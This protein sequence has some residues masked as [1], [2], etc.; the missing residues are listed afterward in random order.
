MEVT[1]G[2]G[3][4]TA[5]WNIPKALLSHHSEFFHAACYGP[6]QEG[7]ENKIQLPDCRPDVFQE[8]I[9]WMY[10]HTSYARIDPNEIEILD[11]YALWILADRILAHQSKNHVMNTIYDYHKL[12]LKNELHM[13]LDA[14]DVS[15]C[16]TNTTSGSLLQKFIVDTLSEHLIYNNYIVYFPGYC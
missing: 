7:L 10:F 3:N 1:V 6:F 11:K 5:T 16:W 4:R 13:E 9:R 15:Y 14:D 2:M 8:F 12:D